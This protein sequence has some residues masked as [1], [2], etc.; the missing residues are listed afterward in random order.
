[1]HNTR[2]SLNGIIFK[3]I[4]IGLQVTPLLVRYSELCH[5][6][7]KLITSCTEGP[8]LTDED[9]RYLRPFALKVDSHMPGNTF[10]KLPYAF[11]ASSVPTWKACQQ[12][13]ANL[14]GFNPQVYDCC[15]NSCCCF[16]GVHADAMECTYC[17]SSRYDAHGK[18]RQ[19]FVYLPIIPRL[20]TLFANAE[21]SSKLRYRSEHKHTADTIRDIFD[22][23]IYRSLLGKKVVV[24]SKELVHTY[25]QDDRDLAVGVS[26]DGIA[27]F[28]HRQKT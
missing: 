14:S 26:T 25:F 12:H 3:S 24:S 4:G 19:E 9:L 13:A 28:R 27:P 1:M 7:L 17:T 18:R 21:L 2:R 8:S 15:I 6:S 10:A 23:K 16:V 20:K 11:P 22:S 5:L